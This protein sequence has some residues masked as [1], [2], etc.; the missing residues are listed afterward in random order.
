MLRVLQLTLRTVLLVWCAL[1]APGQQPGQPAV[2]PQPLEILALATRA[3]CCGPGTM[4][5]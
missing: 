3:S 5:S 2:I 4:S 1:Q